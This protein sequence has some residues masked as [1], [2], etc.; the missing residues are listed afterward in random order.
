VRES[1]LHGV[2]APAERADL[3][4]FGNLSGSAGIAP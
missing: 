1:I 3:F 2:P 4:A